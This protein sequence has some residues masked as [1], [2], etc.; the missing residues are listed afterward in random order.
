MTANEI[1]FQYIFRKAIV[2]GQKECG[3]YGLKSFLW[4]SHA[5]KLI[6]LT[7]NEKSLG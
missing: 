1:D 5:N 4:L 7:V 3:I 2:I 6:I